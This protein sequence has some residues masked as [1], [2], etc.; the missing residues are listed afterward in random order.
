M[1]GYSGPVQSSAT[2]YD[3]SANA[4]SSGL[5]NADALVAA[6]E[7]GLDT[8][9]FPYIFNGATWDR[10]RSVGSAA[11]TS[12]T[13][14]PSSGLLI[15]DGVNSLWRSLSTSTS[16]GDAVANNGVAAILAASLFT[17]NGSTFDRLRSG[18]G[19]GAASTGLQNNAQ[20]VFNG[21]TYDRAKNNSAANISASTQ[22]FCLLSTNPGE[23]SVNG[24]PGVNTTA[25][26]NKA[27][28]GAGVRHICRS[29]T[30]TLCGTAAAAAPVSVYLRDGASGVGTIIW[31]AILINPAG[32]T[33]QI[34]LT[35]LSIVGSA[36]T[37][38]TL[39]FS[40]AAGANTYESVAMTG[41]DTV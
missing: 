20:M 7:R 31:S 10:I 41:Y 27:A 22:N 12:G 17:F 38:M 9:A 13:G 5:N 6:N 28:G 4:L 11:G 39:E 3:T 32:N 25:G 21:S 1:S 29:I 33:V 14:I 8:R 2:I 34:S 15:F 19:D 30:A 37:A 16:Y 24:N 18:Q 35:D 23:W 40:G 26:C 36:N